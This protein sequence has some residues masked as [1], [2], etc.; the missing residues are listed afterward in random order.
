MSLTEHLDLRGG[1]VCWPEPSSDLPVASLPA[2]LADVAIVGAGVMGAMLAERIS[3][4]GRSV[5][6]L[7]RR[8]PAWGATAAST[9]LVMW[10]AD[11]PLSHLARTLGAAE[12]ARRWKCVYA[13]VGELDERIRR[14]AID[15]G[16]RARPEVYLAGTLLDEAGLQGEAKARQA[17]GLTSQ[18]LDSK[19]LA[20]R[21]GLPPRAGLVSDLAFEV[22]PVALTLGLLKCAVGRGAKLIWPVDV[23]AIA[24]IRGGVSLTLADG[25][26]VRARQVVLATGYEA[27]RAYLP[28]AFELDSSFAIASAPGLA[29]LWRENALI[30]EASDPY[31]YARTTRDGRVIIGGADEDFADADRRDAML[32]AKRQALTAQSGDLLG[33][34]GVEA[35]CAWAATFGSSPDG[36]PAI[37]RAPGFDALWLASGF[38]GNGVSFASMAASLICASLDGVPAPDLECFAPDRFET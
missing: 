18:F 11:T 26:D 7:D 13:A 6:V 21:F 36:L 16:W 25:R 38:G 2:D 33:R 32:S 19:V 24:S 8:P 12:A 23:V 1:E 28:P 37:G 10:A 15:C 30:W 17:A 9:A 31:L 3:G 5:V 14:L 20:E 27:A 4:Q 22:D 29:P 35:E 34:E